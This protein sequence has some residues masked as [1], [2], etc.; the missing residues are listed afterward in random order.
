MTYQE[1]EDSLRLKEFIEER[2]GVLEREEL[3]YIMDRNLHPQINHIQLVSADE[4]KYEMWDYEGNY[5]TFVALNYWEKRT[6]SSRK[7]RK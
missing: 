6:N 1:K 4:N 5:F 7:L 3:L 2:G